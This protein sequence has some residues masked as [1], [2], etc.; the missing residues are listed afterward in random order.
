MGGGGY[1]EGEEPRCHI[2]LR[3]WCIPSGLRNVNASR[4]ERHTGH[5]FLAELQ[6]PTAASATQ[7]SYRV[8]SRHR[9]VLLPP[10][11]LALFI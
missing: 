10:P 2:Y 4:H 9:F 7:E 1:V 3:H 6:T 8:Q 5:H 11:L